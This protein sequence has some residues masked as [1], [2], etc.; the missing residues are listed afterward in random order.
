[1]YDTN[2]TNSYASPY[3]SGPLPS[4]KALSA[5]PKWWTLY[6]ADPER[7][8]AIHTKLTGEPFDIAYKREQDQKQFLLKTIQNKWQQGDLRQNDLGDLEE[9]QTIS[10]PDDPTGKQVKK[11]VSLNAQTREAFDKI[12]G[13]KA[14][15]LTDRREVLEGMKPSDRFMLILKAQGKTDEEA[16]QQV[17]AMVAAGRARMSPTPI[18]T[19]SATGSYQAEGLYSKLRRADRSRE[20]GFLQSTGN[21]TPVEDIF[22]LIGQ[23]T[24]NQVREHIT[25]GEINPISETGLPDRR[26]PTDLRHEIDIMRLRK[27]LP[28]MND[29]MWHNFQDRII[30]GKQVLQ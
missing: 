22:S 15:G 8:N 20:A 17:S 12:G 18:S 13:W 23:Q 7:A 30:R 2:L 5:D 29:E 3:E 16:R 28:R 19:P 11:W 24:F 25:G 9:Q 14:L 4:V 10:D 6:K 21:Q 27:G 1:L 26:T